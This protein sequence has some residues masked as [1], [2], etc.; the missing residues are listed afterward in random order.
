[1]ERARGQEGRKHQL[2]II[3]VSERKRV[4]PP[5]G[6]E[7][8]NYEQKRRPFREDSDNEDKKPE[9]GESGERGKNAE[10]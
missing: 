9:R 7:G 4:Q 5:T 8:M 3:S 2:P 10:N 6:F 1:M